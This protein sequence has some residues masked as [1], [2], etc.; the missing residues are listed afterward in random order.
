MFLAGFVVSPNLHKTC[1]PVYLESQIVSA[2]LRKMPAKVAQ[3]CGQLLARDTWTVPPLSRGCSHRVYTVR[4]LQTLGWESRLVGKDHPH[5]PQDILSSRALHHPAPTGQQE[6]G[7]SQ[8]KALKDVTSKCAVPYTGCGLK[9]V[10]APGTFPPI[11][12]HVRWGPRAPLRLAGGPAVESPNWFDG[13]CGAADIDHTAL[14]HGC[15]TARC[16]TQCLWGRS[17]ATGPTIFQAPNHVFRPCPELEG[18][19]TSFWQR[20]PCPKSLIPYKFEYLNNRAV[21]NAPP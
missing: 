14:L 20:C 3:R 15:G 9:P 11:L 12:G 19:L 17:R 21:G 13:P 10:R 7:Y 8:P 6:I 1:C 16:G 2:I 18:C 5:A 4:S